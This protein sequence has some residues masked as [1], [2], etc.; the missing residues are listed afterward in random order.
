MLAGSLGYI[1]GALQV[2]AMLSDLHPDARV[3]DPLV[4]RAPGGL[5]KRGSMP[6]KAAEQEVGLKP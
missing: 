4:A 3:G 5:L 6:A 2:M 1:G